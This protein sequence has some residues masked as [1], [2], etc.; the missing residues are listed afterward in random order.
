M[1]KIEIESPNSVM[2]PF[3]TMSLF[4]TQDEMVKDEALMDDDVCCDEKQT[5]SQMN[6]IDSTGDEYK[7][8]ISET[9]TE[10]LSTEPVEEEKDVLSTIVPIKA[11]VLKRK[12]GAKKEK[13]EVYVLKQ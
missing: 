11:P 10:E 7:F 9:V 2:A 5:L 8:D 4:D 6:S 12:R 3:N 1:L 13:L